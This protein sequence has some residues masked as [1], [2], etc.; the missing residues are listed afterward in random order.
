M[1]S[2]ARSERAALADL[3]DELGPDAA[4]IDDGWATREL[5]AHLVVRERRPLALPGI[6]ISA[7]SGLT[8]REMAAMSK[9]PYAEVVQLIRSGPPRWSPLALVPA[10]DEAVNGSEFFIH[11]EDVRRA[12]DGWQPRELPAG[13][14]AALWS[15]LRR[16]ATMMLRRAP[17][18][19][20]L[21]GPDGQTASGGS[22]EQTVRVSGPAGEL[23]LFCFGRQHVARV[24]TE[25]DAT[26]ASALCAAPLGM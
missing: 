6:A 14:S 13:Q 11:H 18:R 8:D 25:G 26:L 5:A 23:L 1:T 12:Q 16:T 19:V 24:D 22:G 21:H 7:L 4:T 20:V 3:L 9:R 2:Y 17:S 10:L 15:G